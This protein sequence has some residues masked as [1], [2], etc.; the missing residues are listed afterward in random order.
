MRTAANFRDELKSL[1]E[2]SVR[3][4]F[5]FCPT[6]LGHDSDVIGVLVDLLPC[7]DTYTAGDYDGDGATAAAEWV[8]TAASDLDLTGHAALEACEMLFDGLVYHSDCSEF[9]LEYPAYCNSAVDDMGGYSELA[10]GADSVRGI[11]DSAANTGAHAMWREYVS[12]ALLRVD[13]DLE[14]LSGEAWEQV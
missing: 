2:E 3:F 13:C 11:I 4:E 12:D 9:Y 14:R 6:V 8:E 5:T 7:V 10:N 1:I